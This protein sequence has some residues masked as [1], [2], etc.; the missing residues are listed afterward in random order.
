[1]KRIAVLLAF[2]ASAL[3][4]CVPV[5]ESEIAGAAAESSRTLFVAAKRGNTLS[6]IDLASGEEVLRLPSCT[7]PHELASSPD[8]RHV[9]LACYGGTTIDIFRTD[10]LERVVSIDLGSNARPHGIAWHDNG[11]IYVTAEGRRS[12][13][14]VR[15]PLSVTPELQ[16]FGTEKEGSHMLAV[17]PDGRTAWTT[18]LGSRTVPVS[19]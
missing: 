13:F 5:A 9:A 17:S 2:C 1:M 4:A 15:A 19:I 11:G 12:L 8:G 3:P 6:K 16:E 18:D 7:N 10:N 14:W